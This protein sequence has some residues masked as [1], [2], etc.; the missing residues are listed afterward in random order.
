MNI[1]K[2]MA[3]DI[4][5]KTVG[6][7][8]SNTSIIAQAY[9]TIRFN[10]ADYNRMYNLLKTEI[11][12]YKP[13]CI[14]L[15]YPKNMNNTVGEKA[16]ISEMVAKRIKEDFKDIEIFLEDERLTT[17]Y[18]FKIMQNLKKSIKDKKRL[19]DELSAEIILQSFLDRKNE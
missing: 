4:G 8:V 18:S 15:G 2:Y 13:D 3:L 1:K 16:L 9:K 10:E 17:V 14:V 6:I 19:K 7:A 5:S 11:N 12:L